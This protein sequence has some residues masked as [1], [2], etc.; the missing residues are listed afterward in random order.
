MSKTKYTNITTDYVLFIKQFVVHLAWVQFHRIAF[1]QTQDIVEFFGETEQ[2]TQK[3]MFGRI[4]HENRY[5]ISIWDQLFNEQNISIPLVYFIEIYN[6]LIHHTAGNTRKIDQRIG[7]FNPEDIHPRVYV[8]DPFDLVEHKRELAQHIKTHQ[9]MEQR[10]YIQNAIIQEV[11]R[12]PFPFDH[13]DAETHLALLPVIEIKHANAYYKYLDH[14]KKRATNYGITITNE[15][16]DLEIT[17]SVIH[18]YAKPE[19]QQH[20]EI[21][22]IWM[23]DQWI[24]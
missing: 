18:K 20:L 12:S 22:S 21:Y 1:R 23:I 15:N 14:I 3:K 6:E 11:L 16:G 7:M 4:I 17:E 5:S 2:D 24:E 13:N 8:P 9:Q 19:I 10:K